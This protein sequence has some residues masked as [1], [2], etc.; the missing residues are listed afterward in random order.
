M[1]GVAVSSFSCEAGSTRTVT[2]STRTG[3]GTLRLDVVD[4]DTIL[5]TANLYLGGAGLGNGKFATGAVYDVR[6]Y[7]FFPP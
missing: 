3:S 6:S 5:D 7:H 4:R 1:S 2:V